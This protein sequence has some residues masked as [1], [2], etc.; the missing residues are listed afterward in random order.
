MSTAA[1]SSPLPPLWRLG[2]GL[3]LG[4]LGFLIPADPAPES[5]PFLGRAEGTLWLEG[6]MEPDIVRD[7]D[8]YFDT[9][10]GFNEREKRTIPVF[11]QAGP[12]DFLLPLPDTHLVALRID[13]GEGDGSVF[14]RRLRIVDATGRQHFSLLEGGLLPGGQI[15]RIAGEAQ[16][17]RLEVAPPGGNPWCSFRPPGILIPEGAPQRAYLRIGLIW[18]YRVVKYGCLG[19][20]FLL[21]ASSAKGRRAWTIRLAWLLL[22][23]GALSAVGLNSLWKE[24][25]SL[26]LTPSSNQAR[27]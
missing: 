4:V 5:L 15:A 16:G 25:R 23:V 22:G 6:A 3:L 7:M 8:V 14:F 13:L 9:G 21:L 24:A 18:L 12:Q 19:L 2:L 11:E 17:L 1:D 26:S 20:G 10:S 27:H